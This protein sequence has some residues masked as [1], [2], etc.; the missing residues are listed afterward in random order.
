MQGN[1][2]TDVPLCSFQGCACSVLLHEWCCLFICLWLLDPGAPLPSVSVVLGSAL[3]CSL[4]CAR[5][6]AVASALR[7]GPTSV[8]IAP[9]SLKHKVS[10]SHCNSRSDRPQASHDRYAHKRGLMWFKALFWGGSVSPSSDVNVI[11][12]RA[13][14]FTLMQFDIIIV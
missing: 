7:H 2:T 10:V 6:S 3:L 5:Q 14:L 8:H 1:K 13:I 4:V 12:F 9:L 11:A